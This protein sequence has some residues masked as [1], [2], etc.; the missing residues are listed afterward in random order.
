MPIKQIPNIP[1]STCSHVNIR[2]QFKK[3]QN[4]EMNIQLSNTREIFLTFNIH[5]FDLAAC[6][7]VFL[8]NVYTLDNIS[9]G[10]LIACNLHIHL[11]LNNWFCF[12]FCFLQHLIWKCFATYSVSYA[13][14]QLAL[15]MIK[16]HKAYIQQWLFALNNSWMLCWGRIQCEQP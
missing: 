4:G 9:P 5:S 2:P 6:T 8:L 16:M 1:C 12:G 11:K 15:I 13:V 7:F 10:W 3:Q 14:E